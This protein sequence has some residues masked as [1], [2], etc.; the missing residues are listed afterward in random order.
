ML[1]FAKYMYGN[2]KNVFIRVS[3]TTKSESTENEI[4]LIND[5]LNHFYPRFIKFMRK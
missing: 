3:L 5:F 1:F 4:E 2:E